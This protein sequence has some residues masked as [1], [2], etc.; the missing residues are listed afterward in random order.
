MWSQ[1][2]VLPGAPSDQAK[3]SAAWSRDIPPENGE[4]TGK[5]G[6]GRLMSHERT[7]ILYT[8]FMI[9]LVVASAVIIAWVA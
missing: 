2:R 4:D 1:V 5:T 7:I 9:A 3:R 6:K 8:V